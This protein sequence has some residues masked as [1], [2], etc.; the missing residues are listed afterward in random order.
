MAPLFRAAPVVLLFSFRCAENS[1]HILDMIQPIQRSVQRLILLRE[2]QT[3]NIVDRFIEERA[4]RHGADAGF[5][6]Q[7]LAEVDV[8]LAL[9]E[10]RGDV[11]Q[12]E[13]RALG[14]GGTGG[15]AP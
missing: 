12:H 11:G 7:L 6:R 10:V 4:A 8:A 9:L 14:I 2:V 5:S 13:V 1:H 3:H 15:C